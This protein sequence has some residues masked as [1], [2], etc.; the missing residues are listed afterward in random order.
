ML[1][2]M[3]RHWRLVFFL[4]GLLGLITAIVHH[5]AANAGDAEQR[6]DLARL[7]QNSYSDE[8][9]RGIPYDWVDCLESYDYAANGDTD[10]F[11]C[12]TW[13]QQQVTSSL[14]ALRAGGA[15]VPVLESKL[16]GTDDRSRI[17]VDII[18]GPGGSP[19]Y[20]N[21]AMTP[22]FIA[23]SRENGMIE[24][25][26]PLMPD[27]PRY[28]LLKRGFTVASIAYWG[29]NIRT[30]EAPDEFELAMADV[31]LAVEYYRAELGAEPPLITTSMGN[32]LALGALGKTRL[33]GMQILSLVPVMD[34]LQHHT[35]RHSRE[36][37]QEVEEAKANGEFYG[38]WTWFNIYVRPDAGSGPEGSVGAGF[39]FDH[40][41]PLQMYDYIP[42]FIGA[43]DFPWRDVTLRAECSKTVLGDKDPRTRD[44]LAANDDYPAFVEVWQSDHDLYKDEPDK[45][46]ALFADF[47]ECLIAGAAQPR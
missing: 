38:A 12:D 19:F 20:T 29:T 34:G 25:M 18:G 43:A 10:R 40:S 46:R 45:S 4:L 26:G 5:I 6:R 27:M 39:V 32:H 8:P 3:I 1:R 23:R 7:V 17:V 37:A 14:V 42:R 30:I 35:D 16:E 15:I 2:R 22:E 24:S 36:T 21:R 41:Q 28:Q 13:T 9:Q 33:E 47:A 31:T 44:Y 11:V